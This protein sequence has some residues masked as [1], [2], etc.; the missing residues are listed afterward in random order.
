LVTDTLLLAPFADLTMY[1]VRSE[2]TEIRILEYIYDLERAKKLPKISMVI[3]GLGKSQ[4]FG[5]GYGYGYNY[6][7]GYRYGEE[8]KKTGWRKAVDTI[9]RRN[10]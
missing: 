5:Y 8:A 2:V 3:N 4:K 10:K 6:G 7:Y 1:V 9:L